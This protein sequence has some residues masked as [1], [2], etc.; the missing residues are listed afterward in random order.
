VVVS[1]ARR[2]SPIAA[3]TVKHQKQQWLWIAYPWNL[4]EEQLGASSD[5]ARADMKR[6]ALCQPSLFRIAVTWLFN[7][8][9]N[10]EESLSPRSALRDSQC[11]FSAIIC[12]MG[13]RLSEVP[14]VSSYR[15]GRSKTCSLAFD[16][17]SRGY[18]RL[19]PLH[20]SLKVLELARRPTWLALASVRGQLVFLGL[21]RRLGHHALDR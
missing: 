20:D 1:S 12:Q 5:R 14:K 19:Q 9:L 16:F 11:S 21:L 8:R 17:W 10:A 4:G 18:R 7:N 3:R 2:T 13:S 15:S 6:R